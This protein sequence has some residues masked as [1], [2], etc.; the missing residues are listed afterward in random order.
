MPQTQEGPV[1]EAGAGAA[2]LKAQLRA[3]AIAARQAMDRAVI[4]ASDRAITETVRD[5]VRAAQVVAAYAPMAR[6][7]GGPE[8]LDSIAQ[9]VGTLMLP[10]LRED[11]LLDWAPYDGPLAMSAPY[12]RLRQPTTAR[13]GVDAVQAAAL[14]LVPALNVDRMGNRLGRGGGYYDRTLARLAPGT[15][16]VALL[17]D[18]ELVDL[19]PVQPHDQPVTAVVMPQRQVAV[20]PGGS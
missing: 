2:A 14:V 5:M 6:E 4:D 19:L 13:L 9:V 12:P 8:F 16:L 1:A 11:R 10:V 18:G 3:A 20:E 7:P 17:Y 15:R